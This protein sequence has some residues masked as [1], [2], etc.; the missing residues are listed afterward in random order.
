MSTK[1]LD[2]G[3]EV[4]NNLMLISDSIETAKLMLKKN[5]ELTKK[6]K[7]CRCFS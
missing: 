5:E 1:E 2:K 6:I 3:I 7:S 4:I